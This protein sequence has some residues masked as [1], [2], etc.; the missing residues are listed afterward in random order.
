[1]IEKVAYAVH[2]DHF[3]APL[4]SHNRTH[5]CECEREKPEAVRVVPAAKRKK[6]VGPE[7]SKSMISFPLART[8]AFRVPPVPARAER[9]EGESRTRGRKRPTAV[10][11]DPV[12]IWRTCVQDAQLALAS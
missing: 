6:I 2:V 11:R 7:K 5:Q 12:L 8:N 10:T 3:L 4:F 9:A 1:M